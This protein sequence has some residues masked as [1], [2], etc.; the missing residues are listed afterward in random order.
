MCA[1]FTYFEYPKFRLAVVYAECMNVLYYPCSIQKV[2]TIQKVS[3]IQ[4]W[5]TDMFQYSQAFTFY[6]LRPNVYCPQTFFRCKQYYNILQY[7]EKNNAWSSSPSLVDLKHSLVWNSLSV[8]WFFPLL[9]LW[10]VN[11]SK[12]DQFGCIS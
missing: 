12:I 10:N 4:Y 2:S 9:Y 7:S 6:Y 11:I 1:T 3:S 8:W 5:S